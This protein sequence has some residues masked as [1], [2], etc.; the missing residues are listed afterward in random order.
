M[1]ATTTYIVLR[2]LAGN[3]PNSLNAV[4]MLLEP[5]I[6]LLVMLWRVAWICTAVTV[7]AIYA[8]AYRRHRMNRYE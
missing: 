8:Q 3:S 2:E 4:Q 7:I 1:E 5:H 6:D